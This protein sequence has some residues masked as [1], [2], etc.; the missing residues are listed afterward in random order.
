MNTSGK[1]LD[2][3]NIIFRIL[4]QNGIILAAFSVLYASLLSQT[5]F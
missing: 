4:L 1:K 3:K 2:Q 5:P